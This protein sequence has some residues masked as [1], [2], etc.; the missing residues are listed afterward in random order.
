MVT[1]YSNLS[2]NTAFVTQKP[3]KSV[4]LDIF[5]VYDNAVIRFQKVESSSEKL[6]YVS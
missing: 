5:Y 6:I 1:R 2:V 4:R 3:Q